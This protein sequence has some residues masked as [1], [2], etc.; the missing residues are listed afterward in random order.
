VSG[1]RCGG[2]GSLADELR[3]Y[4]GGLLDAL[5]PLVERVRDRQPDPSTPEPSSCAACPVCMLIIVLHGGH[6]E[7][8]ARLAEQV[9]GLLTVL[10]TAL[11]EGVGADGLPTDPGPETHPR[12]IPTPDPHPEPPAA[13]HVGRA[14]RPP[15]GP[16]VQ[17]IPVDRNGRWLADAQ[18][19]EPC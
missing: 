7:L 12:P 18:H 1:P 17:R 9:S 5:E 16:K 6:S 14:H 13:T 19:C 8:A 2:H 11:D 10:R 15:R 3:Q 4:A